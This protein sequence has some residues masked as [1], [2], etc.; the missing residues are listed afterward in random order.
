MTL[1]EQIQNEAVDGTSDLATVL[2]KCRVLSAKLKNEE[3]TDWVIH[4]LDGYFDVPSVPAYRV[5]HGQCFGDFAGPFGLSVRNVQFGE[6]EI[7]PNFRKHLAFRE[8]RDGVEGIRQM[9]DSS[10]GSKFGIRIGWPADVLGAYQTKRVAEHLVLTHAW[11][12]LSENQITGTLSTIRNRILNFALEI[13]EENPHAGEAPIGTPPIA[14]EKTNQIFHNTIIV[15]GNV[16]SLAGGNVG[17]QVNI[18]MVRPGDLE[19]LKEF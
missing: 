13:M 16:S 19:S 3:F 10:R 14:P 9:L 6:S 2:R 1:L 5:L 7:L 11:T 18:E 17:N 12:M 8:F 4:E 15:H